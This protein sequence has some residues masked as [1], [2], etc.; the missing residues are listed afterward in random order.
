[1]V[2]EQPAQ[3]TSQPAPGL[4]PALLSI[5]ACPS[6]DHAAL[7]LAQDGTELVCTVCL[8]RFPIRDGI[9]VLL[10]DEAVP[11]P[12]GLGVAAQPR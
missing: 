12:Q 10:A 5:L 8:T 6:A 9:P 4:D 3:R 11:G 7:R 2:S 1:M